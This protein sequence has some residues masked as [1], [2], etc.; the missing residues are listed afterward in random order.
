MQQTKP[1][2][3]NMEKY[4]INTLEVKKHPE[5]ANLDSYQIFSAQTD[6]W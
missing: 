4:P 6:L 3:D 2:Y 1:E 5:S